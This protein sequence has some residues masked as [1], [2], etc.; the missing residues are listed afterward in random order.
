MVFSMWDQ[1]FKDPMTTDAGVDR[2]VRYAAV[3]DFH[4]PDVRVCGPNR[5]PSP[6]AMRRPLD[7]LDPNAPKSEPQGMSS[8]SSHNAPAIYGSD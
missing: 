8:V 2:V 7:A 1:I 6:S 3:L 4:G 5:S